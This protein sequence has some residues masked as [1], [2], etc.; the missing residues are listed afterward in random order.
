MDPSTEQLIRDYLNRMSVAAQGRLTG[1]ERRQLLARTRESIE[2]EAGTPAAS[3]A[4][5]V[6]KMLSGLGEPEALVGQ[7]HAR[8]AAARG[9]PGQAPARAGRLIAQPVAWLTRRSRRGRP[10]YMPPPEPDPASPAP[11]TGEIKIQSRPITARRRPGAPLQP[12]PA[13]QHRPPRAGTAAEH[14]NGSAASTGTPALNAARPDVSYPAAPGP[15]QADSGGRNFERFLAMLAGKPDDPPAAAPNPSAGPADRPA[16]EA[17]PGRPEPPG[18]AAGPEPGVPGPGGPPEAP[19]SAGP[20]TGTPASA[21]PPDTPAPGRP[22]GR[23]G[24]PAS[25]RAQG[26]PHRPAGQS[27]PAGQSAPAGRP[28]QPSQA[29]AATRSGGGPG[30]TVPVDVA[31][32]LRDLANSAVLLARQRPLETFA[33]VLLGLGGLIFPPVWLFGALVALLSPQWDL[34]DKWAG[35]A[36]PPLLVILGAGG[37]IALGGK[38]ASIGAYAHEAWMFADYLSRVVAVLGAAYLTWRVKRGPR[39]PTPPWNR[40]HRI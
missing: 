14:Q 22:S 20:G 37:A 36:G 7:E 33:I 27:G 4:A 19:A 26:W 2:R 34:R 28:G 16:P 35:L 6:R 12:R 25:S 39:P 8:L 29:P 1:A 15:G 38:H 17:P 13:R 18:P 40:P 9:E 10:V 32:S 5:E 30:G 31:G 3:G 21:G 24:Q 11:L 23:P